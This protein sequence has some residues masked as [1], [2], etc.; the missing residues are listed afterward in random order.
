MALTTC[1]GRTLATN[2]ARTLVPLGANSTLQRAFA[3][4]EVPGDAAKRAE[5]PPAGSASPVASTSG[6]TNKDEEWS[7]VIDEASGKTYYWNQATGALFCV[8]NVDDDQ[9]P[10]AALVACS[11]LTQAT[12]FW[13]RARP[14][15]C[16]CQVH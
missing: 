6:T 16:P 7:E 5:A 3:A 15:P 10:A 13:R 14:R 9:L 1:R 2:L 8:V 11:M 4:G 12:T